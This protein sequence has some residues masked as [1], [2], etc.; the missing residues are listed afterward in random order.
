MFTGIIECT[1]KVIDVEKKENYIFT[2]NASFSPELK[3][4][5]SISHN[6]VCLSVSE[7]LDDKKYQV[8][9]VKETLSKTNLSH[10][11]IGDL[12]NLERSMQLNGRFDGHIVQ[13]HVDEQ[14][15]CIEIIEE[16]GSWKFVFSHNNSPLLVEKG[17]VCLNGISLTVFE[18]TDKTFSVAIIPYTFSHTNI[19]HIKFGDKLNIEYD[20]IGKY[21]E[22]Q[23]SFKI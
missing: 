3:I 23:L 6:G 10:L 16:T 13:G 19:Q 12:I 7:I 21:V 20:L 14:S 1:G 11:N 22:R 8:I 5:D 9:A 15:T 18:I 17:S 4:N 2:I